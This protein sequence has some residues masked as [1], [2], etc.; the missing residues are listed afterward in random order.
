[1]AFKPKRP[2]SKM[3]C[4]NITADRY[5]DQHALLADQQRKER[6]RHYDRY[7]RDQQAAK[8]YNS[9]EWK[10]VRQ[11]ALIKDHGLCQDC[12]EEQRITTADVVDHIKPLR[13]FW[14]L[15]L[16]LSN[17]RSLCHMHHNRKTAEDKQK[18]R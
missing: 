6:H 2:C 10:R 3:G 11:Q 17:L 1:M 18:Y 8:F 4:R 13:L 7:Q 15:R 5:C 9:I 16:T 14:H 12:L